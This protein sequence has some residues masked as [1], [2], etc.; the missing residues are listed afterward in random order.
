MFPLVPSQDP[1][2][3]P[4]TEPHLEEAPPLIYKAP[5]KVHTHAGKW[6]QKNTTGVNT[7]S[8]YSFGCGIWPKPLHISFWTL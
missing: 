5:L 7:K 4:W 3:T 8:P 1:Q 6:G 2:T